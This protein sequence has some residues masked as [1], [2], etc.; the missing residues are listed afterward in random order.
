MDFADD[1]PLVLAQEAHRGTS[2][3]PE[4]R[5]E[6]ERQCY[7]ALMEAD[8]ANMSRLADTDRKREILE[9]RFAV[10][11][12]EYRDRTLIL[13]AAKSRCI[14]TMIA[15]PSNFP[16]A[17]AHKASDAADRRATEL[18][19]YRERALK[20]MRRDLTPEA[21]PVRI[22]DADA[23]DRL[24]AQLADAEALQDKMRAHNAAA[25]KSGGD[26]YAPYQL[27]NNAANIRRLKQRIAAVS[28]AQATAPTEIVGNGLRVEDVPAE[29]R[30]RIYFP[31]KPE[32]AKREELKSRGFRWAPT[33]GCWQAYRNAGA[34]SFA[35]EIVSAS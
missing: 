3:S 26:R 5:G 35:K 17:R 18:L 12:A 21:Q 16:S 13:L 23:V 22:G 4:Q 33:L 7:A 14:S 27:T 6:L 15:G 9:E 29:N 24:A 30:V 2:H 28:Q 34:V 10:Y 11:R 31:G 8:Y 1:I 20:S 25:R 32:A 19:E